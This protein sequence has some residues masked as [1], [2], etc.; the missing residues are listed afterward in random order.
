MNEGRKGGDFPAIKIKQQLTQLS[1]Y[2]ALSL[3]LITQE[4]QAGF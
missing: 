1:L 3:Q 2:P 4:A